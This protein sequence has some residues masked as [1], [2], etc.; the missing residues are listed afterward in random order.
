MRQTIQATILM[1]FLAAG[2]VTMLA[3]A[4]AGEAHSR[5][6]SFP[7]APSAVATGSRFA[8]LSW[9]GNGLRLRQAQGAE[10]SIHSHNHLSGIPVTADERLHL[11][12]H[13][14]FSPEAI[15]GDLMD[16]AQGEFQHGLGQSARVSAGFQ[17]RYFTIVAA[18][19]SS[20][21]FGTYLFPSTL[22]QNPRSSRM[23]SGSSVWQRLGY[24]V[25]RVAITHGDDGNP[26]FNGSL[27]LSAAA[28]SAMA[29]LYSA[30]SQRGFAA[31]ASRFEGSLLGN[32]QG[33]LSRE[34]LPDI[35]HFFWK[36][37]TAGIDRLGKLLFR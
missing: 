12:L 16:A 33:N 14:S 10:R 20:N 35:E 24:A 27:L 1:V 2:Q 18:H 17:K 21:F 30:P 9:E 5:R 25:T 7:D 4:G 22:H 11:F 31:T 36:H 26:A 19:A 8:T 3:Q 37:G 28:S 34:F 6:E 13:N 29:N 32:L 15:R 23:G